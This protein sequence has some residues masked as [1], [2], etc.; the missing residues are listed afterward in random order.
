MQQ[1]DSDAML[2]RSQCKPAAGDQIKHF[3]F[4][5]GFDDD[6]AEPSALQPFRTRAQRAHG[7]GCA[8]HQN[9]RRIDPQ[10]QQTG[11]MNLAGFERRKILPHPQKP[12]VRTEHAH[13][14]R[15]CKTGCGRFFAGR[16]RKHLMQCAK[17]QSSAQAGVGGPVTEGRARRGG[18]ILQKACK[19]GFY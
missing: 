16:G 18:D 5:P 17:A 2:L 1:D 7:V 12:F 3:G 9:A 19:T 11:R 4:A 6:R 13:G 14:Q 10:F 8:H 15:Q